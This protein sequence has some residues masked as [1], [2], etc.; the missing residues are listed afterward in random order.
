MQAL[1]DCQTEVD[2]ILAEEKADKR[3][4]KQLLSQT[5]TCEAVCTSTSAVCAEEAG[6]RLSLQLQAMT[7]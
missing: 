3:S 2:M 4:I 7:A 1:A 6:Q 5:A